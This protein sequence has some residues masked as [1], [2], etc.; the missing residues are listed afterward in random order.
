MKEQFE[1][2]LK[3]ICR[4]D[5]DDWFLHWEGENSSPDEYLGMVNVYTRNNKYRINAKKHKDGRTYLGCTVSCR[6][7]RAG[8]D[9]TRGNDLPD[10]EFSRKT[11]ERIKNAIVQ[12]ELVKI[13]KPVRQE[14]DEDP[15]EGPSIEE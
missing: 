12:Y 6:M 15:V 5:R 10:G 4:W 14:P 13:A 7:S 2:W 1:E 8:E 11:W 3:E 9:W